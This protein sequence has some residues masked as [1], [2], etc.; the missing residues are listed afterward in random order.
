M[1]EPEMLNKSKYAP[2]IERM[3][4]NT[5]E[6]PLVTEHNVYQEGKPANKPL[7]EEIVQD[8]LLPGSRIVGRENLL[9]LHGL[10]HK[11]KPCLVLMEH[12]SNFDLPCFTWLLEASGDDY[13]EVADSVVAVAGVK[14]NEESPLVLAF[15]E[16]FTRVVLYP[17]RGIEAIADAKARHEAQKRRAKINIAA[18]KRLNTLRREGKLI[19]V[20]PSGTRYRPWDPSTARG[21]K[22]I[23]TYLKF[24][25]YMVMVSINGNTLLPNRYGSMGEDFPQKDVMI[26]TVSPVW[27]CSDFRRR[28]LKGREHEEDTKQHVVDSVMAALGRLHERTENARQRLLAEAR[29]GQPPLTGPV[30]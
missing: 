27:K 26:Y 10:A 12:Y 19:L 21:L 22:E 9:E 30:S 16:V 11:K 4:A 24:Y 3:V 8:L 18:L 6:A 23:D 20:F 17:S 28:A 5:T 2:L 29:G 1:A 15:T 13:R 7:V 25:S 14:L